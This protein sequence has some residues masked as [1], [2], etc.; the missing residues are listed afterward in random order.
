MA[1]L[2]EAAH[3]FRSIDTTERAPHTCDTCQETTSFDLPL[4]GTECAYC[5]Q[6]TD[7][8]RGELVLTDREREQLS[9]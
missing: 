5:G 9:F 1:H 2:A 6:R 8:A 4:G 7:D 3:F